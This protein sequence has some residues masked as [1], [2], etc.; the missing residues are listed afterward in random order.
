VD[1]HFHRAPLSGR[2]P[3]LTLASNV[4]CWIRGFS[5]SHPDLLPEGFRHVSQNW[6]VIEDVPTRQ[7]LLTFRCILALEKYI[8]TPCEFTQPTP[9]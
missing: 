1:A 7:L 3:L 5:G 8:D 9:P 6:L 4:S 2:D